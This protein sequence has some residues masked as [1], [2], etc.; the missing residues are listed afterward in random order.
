[1]KKKKNYDINKNTNVLAYYFI[2]CE[3]FQKLN[4]FLKNSRLNNTKYVKIKNKQ[5]WWF[6]LLKKKN[7]LKLLNEKY[8]KNEYHNITSRMSINE[9]D[10]FKQ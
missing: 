7:E 6:T 4:L 2:R 8:N 1:M 3:L 10:L 9:L 5:S